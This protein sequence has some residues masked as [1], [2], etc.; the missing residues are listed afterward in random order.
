[1]KGKLT[2]YKV[3]EE[4]A[5]SVADQ[6]MDWIALSKG[7]RY[8]MAISGGSTPNLLFAAL[9]SR[10]ADSTIWQNTHFW[11]VDERMVRSAD[12][13]S[14]YGT[15][16][17]LLFSKIRI[18]EGNIHRIRGER[19]PA[20]EAVSY[21]AEIAGSVPMKDGW[22]RF[23]LVLLGMGEDGHTASIF[24]GH[25]ALLKS[26]HICEVA[27]HPATQQLRI[28]LTGEVINRAATVCFLVTGTAK[29]NRLSEILSKGEMGKLLPAGG[30]HP[31]NGELIW[32]A[33]RNAAQLLH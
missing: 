1:M 31:V 28:T 22:P 10:Y 15:A 25:L 20:L 24:P 29:A 26:E 6:L 17:R 30:I 7:K 13:E 27:T 14:N 19:N 23:N 32:F 5:S 18:P 33:D 3:P 4:L 21:S 16:Q 2:I 11:W 12:P 8:D 9:A